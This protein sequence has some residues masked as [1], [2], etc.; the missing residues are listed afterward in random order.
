MNIW[1][2]YL[3]LLRA[4]RNLAQR[5]R[6]REAAQAHQQAEEHES[7][8]ASICRWPLDQRARLR[9]HRINASTG[10]RAR[11]GRLPGGAPHAGIRS[12]LCA[13]PQ[14]MFWKTSA[15]VVR[16][17]RLSVSR[18]THLPAMRA[19]AGLLFWLTPITCHFS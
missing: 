17:R 11:S 19:A 2:L 8:E 9:T 7:H 6:V 5:L 15:A 16:F 3:L 18:A 13:L 14:T 12:S 10:A 1:F 4:T